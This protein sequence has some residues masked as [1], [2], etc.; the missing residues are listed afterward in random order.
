MPRRPVKASRKPAPWWQPTL[1]NG[2]QDWREYLMWQVGLL[3]TAFSILYVLLLWRGLPVIDPTVLDRAILISLSVDLVASLILW[4]LIVKGWSRSK[5]FALGFMILADIFAKLLFLKA[6]N[7]G[8]PFDSWWYLL[9]VIGTGL[10][11]VGTGGIGL[12]VWIRGDDVNPWWK[13]K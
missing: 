10:Y 11:L 1:T 8:D 12:I 13:R 4:R 2:K 9:L 5:R 7:P 3:L 6:A